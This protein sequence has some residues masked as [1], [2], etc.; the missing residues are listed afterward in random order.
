[1]VYEKELLEEVKADLSVQLDQ[2][3]QMNFP[4]ISRYLKQKWPALNLDV[5]DMKLD[6]LAKCL[7]KTAGAKV[8]QKGSYSMVLGK[9]LAQAELMRDR[10]KRSELHEAYM[11]LIECVRELG[12][13]TRM[14]RIGGRFKRKAPNFKPKSHGFITKSGNG[15]LEF[16]K[17]CPGVWVDPNADPSKSVRIEMREY[18]LRSYMREH[19]VAMG[20]DPDKI[21]EEERSR[22]SARERRREDRG[23]RDRDRD[24]RGRGRD[25]RRDRGDRDRDRGDRDRDR[26]SY[27]DRRRSRSRDRDRRSYDRERRRY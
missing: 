5:H 4:M 15:L 10:K 3:K 22:R 20:E 1:M 19:A 14:A 11:A 25:D 23:G 6:D 21:D 8:K 24:D 12:G 9:E 27:R 16:A 17:S 7:E 13:S 18:S 26:G 2:R